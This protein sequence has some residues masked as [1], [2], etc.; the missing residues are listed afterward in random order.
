MSS[1]YSPEERMGRMEE[2]MDDLESQT[3]KHATKLDWIMYL[4]I[5]NF[6][7]VIVNLVSQLT[8]KP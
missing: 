3:E 4:L 1:Y 2:R 8:H 5:A 7:A 6:A